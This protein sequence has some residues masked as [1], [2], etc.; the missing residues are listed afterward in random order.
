MFNWALGQGLVT[1]SSSR[2]R[3]AAGNTQEYLD[4]DSFS[5]SQLSWSGSQLVVDAGKENYPCVEISW[6][7]CIGFCNAKSQQEGLQAC[8]TLSNGDCDFS[9]NGWRLPTEAEWEKGARGGVAGQR[10][11]HG[12]TITHSDANYNSRSI[13]SYDTSATRD[14]HPTWNTGTWPYTAPVGSFAANGYGLHDMAGNVFEWCHD[15]YGSGYY[16]SSLGTDPTG[17]SS[18]SNRVLRGGSWLGSVFHARCA[19]RRVHADVLGHN[20]GF[21]LARGR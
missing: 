5:V 17:P 21:R 8:Y 18:G 6:W 3:G 15:W 20:L 10:F 2:L 1:S 13:Y 16:G 12:D 9:L 7:G 14:H 4:L 19:H 11:P